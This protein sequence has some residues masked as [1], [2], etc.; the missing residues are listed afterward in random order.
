M[1]KPGDVHIFIEKFFLYKY[2]HVESLYTC[3]MKIIGLCSAG[4]FLLDTKKHT[5]MPRYPFVSL[6]KWIL[7]Y[8]S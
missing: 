8:G 7:F 1:L 2:L 6:I 4:K 3:V 5:V